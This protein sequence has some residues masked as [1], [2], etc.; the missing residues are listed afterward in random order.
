M[1]KLKIAHKHSFKNRKELSGEKMCGCF[2]CGKIFPA[3][4]IEDW[5]EENDGNETAVCPYCYIDSVIGE[6]DEYPLTKEFLKEM[7]EYYF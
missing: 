3:A 1:E 6:S 5:Y 7:N 2:Y 4:E